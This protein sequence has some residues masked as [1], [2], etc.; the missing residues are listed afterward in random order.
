MA[1]E[2]N[3]KSIATD[4]E[5]YLLNPE[6]WDTDVAEVLIQQYEFAGHKKVI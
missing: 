3:G 5:N 2:V 4:N 1:I 6:G